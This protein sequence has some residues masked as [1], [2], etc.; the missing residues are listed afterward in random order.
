MTKKRIK[1]VDW[2]TQFKQRIPGH[3]KKAKTVTELAIEMSELNLTTG[4]NTFLAETARVRRNIKTLNKISPGCIAESTKNGQKVYRWSE[5]ASLSLTGISAEEL[6]A[7]GVLQKYGTDL[8]SRRVRRVLEPYFEK[9]R[10][11]LKSR[12]LSS[13]LSEAK[14]ERT[15]AD[16]LS[17]IAVIPDVLPFQGPEVK[18]EVEEMIH[19]GL[20]RQIALSL[21]FKGKPR[22]RDNPGLTVSPLGIAQQGVRTYLIALDNY[23]HVVKRFLIHR[24]ESVDHARDD[25]ITPKNWD[26]DAFL[27]KGIG[28]PQLPEEF[29]DQYG[30]AV[31]MKFWV[32][33]DT[34]WIKETPFYAKGSVAKITDNADRSYVIEAD[35]V[36]SEELIRW[37][38]SMSY[39]VKV[40]EPAWLANRIIYDI[41]KTSEM[42]GHGGA[43]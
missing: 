29:H 24:I 37:L 43:Q 27:R 25:H 5:A 21:W 30:M 1:N 26:L 10:E 6:I 42:Y 2:L 20:F 12:G 9:T 18:P 28:L 16:W 3:G 15:V 11:E 4:A 19:E 35:I 39:H 7:M 33:S 38:L 36:L 32:H 34:Q 22:T 31:P 41:Q 40:I 17:R 23:A 14:A 8:I 13:G